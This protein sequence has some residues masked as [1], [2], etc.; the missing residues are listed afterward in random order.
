MLRLT[1]Q[2]DY[3]LGLLAFVARKPG[4]THTAREL[5][6][7]SSYPLPMVT[8]ILKLLTRSGLLESRRGV[9]GGYSLARSPEAVTAADIIHALEGPI[10]LTGCIAGEPGDC[11]KEP[12]C[13]IQGHLRVLNDAIR[14]TLQGVTLASMTL[15]AVGD[16]VLQID[17]A[18][19]TQSVCNK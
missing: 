10:A 3:G 14:A 12:I 15:P 17:S 11:D 13:P 2:A 1:K 4:Q 18:T 8:K 7:R 6:A 19:S 9:K 5:S 16:P